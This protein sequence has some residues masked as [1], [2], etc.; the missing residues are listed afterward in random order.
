MNLPG[1]P[2][3]LDQD[4]DKNLMVENLNLINENKIESRKSDAQSSNLTPNLFETSASEINLLESEKDINVI[5]SY[6]YQQ[7]V[8]YL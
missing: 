2:T 4:N 5:E 6:R 7:H 8:Y 3:R 1:F